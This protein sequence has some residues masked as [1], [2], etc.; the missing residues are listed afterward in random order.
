[1]NA[2]I[3]TMQ[4]NERHVLMAFIVIGMVATM[5]T[6]GAFAGAD[7]TFAAVETLL[8]NWMTG[9]YGKVAAI[10]ALAVG[11]AISIV[12]QSLMFAAAGVGIAIAAITGPAIVT[13]IVT[14]TL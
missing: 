14:A 1:M 7:V 2:T 11:L 13:G 6:Q 4:Y 8:T 5:M 9:S 3:T 12:K 10:G